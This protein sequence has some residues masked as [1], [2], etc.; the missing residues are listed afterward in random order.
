MKSDVLN[1]PQVECKWLKLFF[2]VITDLNI[3]LMLLKIRQA[4]RYK[5]VEENPYKPGLVLD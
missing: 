1:G 4:L 3:G 2:I 5:G